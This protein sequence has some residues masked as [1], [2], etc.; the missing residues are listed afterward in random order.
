MGRPW[1]MGK[2][3]DNSAPCTALVPAAKSGHPA[4]GAI[5]LKV[6]G[7]VKQKGD[8]SELIWNM[9]ETISYLSGTDHA[10]ARRPDL[11]RHARGRRPGQARRQA[12][13][14]RR[15]LRRSDDHL[16]KITRPPAEDDMQLRKLGANGP[17]V[18][19]QGLGC[20]G[21][22]IS[23]GEPND[24]ES[25]ATIHRA[26]DLG[27][28]LIVTSDAYGAGVNEAAGRSRAEGTRAARADRDQVRQSRA[29]RRQSDRA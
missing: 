29:R 24:E 5:W 9:P 22:S 4:K 13:R 25:I 28:N 6:N 7:A 18:S 26:L 20:M 2:A 11:F 14:P 15:R 23:Y 10:A 1:E 16:R 12:R 8:L 27:V 17:Q 19:A 3:F 21:M